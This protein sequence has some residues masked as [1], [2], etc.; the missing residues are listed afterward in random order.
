MSEGSPSLRLSHGSETSFGRALEPLNLFGNSRLNPRDMKN[1]CVSVTLA[2]LMEF[3]NVHDFWKDLFGH[4]L[5]DKPLDEKAIQDMLTRIVWTFEWVKMT[6]GQWEESERL[7]EEKAGRE[8]SPPPRPHIPATRCI[9]WSQKEFYSPNNYD[10]W[11]HW[12]QAK[13]DWRPKRPWS[14]TRIILL[15]QL[16]FERLVVHAL[17]S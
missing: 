13:G 11:L 12:N 6:R 3:S 14:P 8:P 1:N 15:D 9:C 5:E 16:N 4:D 2:R 17:Q 10:P 7:R